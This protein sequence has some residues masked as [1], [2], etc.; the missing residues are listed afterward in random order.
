M[1]TSVEAWAFAWTAVR[2]QLTQEAGN[3]KAAVLHRLA[4]E[5]V[6]EASRWYRGRSANSGDRFL[7]EDTNGTRPI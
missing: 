5:E 7:A 6:T 4:S 1:S 2:K 3:A